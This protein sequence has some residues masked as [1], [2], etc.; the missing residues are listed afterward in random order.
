MKYEKW[1]LTGLY[2]FLDFRET[3]LQI[4]YQKKLSLFLI[5]F[6]LA[7]NIHENQPFFILI[8]M[9]T[10]VIKLK[11]FFS[12]L[13]I[14]LYI[15]TNNIITKRYILKKRRF[16][17]FIYKSNLHKF[18]ENTHIKTNFIFYPIPTL[19]FFSLPIQVIVCW[20]NK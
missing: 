14:S 2:F 15:W 10:F 8:F 16:C 3:W 7:Q 9:L 4:I 1:N 17:K 18:R 19:N 20:L 12:H 13:F 5:L 6:T 11:Q